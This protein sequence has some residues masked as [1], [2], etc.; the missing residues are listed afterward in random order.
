MGH[1][2]SPPP[3]PKYLDQPYPSSQKGGTLIAEDVTDRQTHERRLRDPDGYRPRCC[4]RCGHGKLHVH[5]YRWRVLRAERP[6]DKGQAGDGEA[7]RLRVVRHRCAKEACRAR[8]QTLPALLAPH[9]WRRWEVVEAATV[10]RRPHDWPP[11][12]GRTRRR[13]RAR[14]RMAA[15]LLTQVLATSGSAVLQHV[16]P[17]LGV[18]ATRLDLL[19]ALALPLS[20]AAAL[21]HRLAPGVRLV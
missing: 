18:W 6:Q 16:A 4:P 10:G 11:V 9:L 21:L 5:D 3:P 14:W 1:R 19:R 20:A 2:P 17:R 8:W 13:W 7:A 12:P 15:R